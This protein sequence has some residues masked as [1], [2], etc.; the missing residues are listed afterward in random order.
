[1]AGI[2]LK[3]DAKVG[4]YFQLSKFLNGFILYVDGEYR[5]IRGEIFHLY[6]GLH[7]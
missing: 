6:M 2:P 4:I 5:Q 3:S 7:N 1:M